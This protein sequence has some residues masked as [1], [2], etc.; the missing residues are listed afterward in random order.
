MPGVCKYCERQFSA[1]CLTVGR[2]ATAACL[3]GFS[4]GLKIIPRGQLFPDAREEEIEEGYFWPAG[5][6]EF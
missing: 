5:F 4:R 2:A 1:R 6:N 3:V